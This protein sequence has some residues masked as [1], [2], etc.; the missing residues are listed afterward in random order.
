M[1][2]AKP[3][4]KTDP[5]EAAGLSSSFVGVFN[6][7]RFGLTRRGVSVVSC[8]L[9]HKVTEKPMNTSLRSMENK[10]G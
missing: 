2:L 7:A 9:A 8:A 6:V 5:F 4:L 1:V 10:I 3:S